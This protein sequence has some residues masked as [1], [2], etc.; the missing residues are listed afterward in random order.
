MFGELNWTEIDHAVECYAT[1]SA[2][3]DR[4]P[5]LER[6]LVEI[7]EGI[8]SRRPTM[9]DFSD[10]LI[11]NP[12]TKEEVIRKIAWACQHIFDTRAWC[13]GQKVLFQ[14]K[15][16]SKPKSPLVSQLRRLGYQSTPIDLLFIEQVWKDFRIQDRLDAMLVDLKQGI[17]YLVKGCSYTQAK[18]HSPDLWTNRASD[19][20]FAHDGQFLSRLHVKSDAIGTLLLARDVIAGSFPNLKVKCVFITIDDVECTWRYQVQDLSSADPAKL[21]K[22]KICLDDYDVISTHANFQELFEQDADA[23]SSLPRWAASD[24]LHSSPVDRPTRAIMILS[25]MWRT[26]AISKKLCSFRAIDLAEQVQVTYKI[27][28]PTDLWRHD[29]EDCLERGRFIQRA[30]GAGSGYAI[31]AKGVARL[32]LLLRRFNPLVHLSSS[33]FLDTV[34]K[35]AKVWASAPVL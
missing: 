27:E 6:R 25:E 24:Y 19:S 16:E 14:R 28:Y 4:F 32:L 29:I 31:S 33:S 18:N 20:L 22:T 5:E 7:C 11:R 3:Q 21:K 1:V 9:Q 30:P 15:G 10:V 34:S 12:Q 13:V 26:Q 8:T 17:V 2:Y 23:F 35:H